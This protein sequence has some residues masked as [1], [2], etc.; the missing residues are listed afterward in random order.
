[1]K[2]VKKK[3]QRIKAF[4]C[5]INSTT[6]NII[7]NTYL[8][9][10]IKYGMVVMWDL[11]PKTRRH[12]MKAIL[13]SCTK[14]IK[15]YTQQSQNDFFEVV[16]NYETLGLMIIQRMLK[17]QAKLQHYYP[18]ELERFN[19]A[20]K[21]NN[22]WEEYTKECCPELEGLIDYQDINLMDKDKKLQKRKIKLLY[23]E[24]KSERLDPE[25]G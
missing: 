15:Q 16:S 25:Q 22:Y 14:N 21:N 13:R 3:L 12:K 10:K 11:I 9:S 19:Q 23:W 8:F 2:V 17:I 5:I 20:W 24:I 1:M 4:G 6:K 18:E 7:V